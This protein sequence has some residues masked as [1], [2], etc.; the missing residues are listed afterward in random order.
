MA[1]TRRKSQ[2]SK[3][4]VSERLKRRSEGATQRSEM[5]KKLEAQKA[6]AKKR[7]AKGKSSSSSSMRKKYGGIVGKKNK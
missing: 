1:K 3:L 7:A 2:A 6:R 4:S 5:R